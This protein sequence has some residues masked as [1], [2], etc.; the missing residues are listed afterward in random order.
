MHLSCS[1]AASCRGVHEGERATCPGHPCHARA[2]ACCTA[3]HAVRHSGGRRQQRPAQ[4]WAAPATCPPRVQQE[5]CRP[6]R[7][8]RPSRCAFMRERAAH[9]GA[10]IFCSRARMLASA[11]ADRSKRSCSAGAGERRTRACASCCLPPPKLGAA[12]ASASILRVAPG[13]RPLTLQSAARSS[14]R[15]KR[16]LAERAPCISNIK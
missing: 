10:P 14:M 13:G 11:S 15:A 4:D 5:C 8:P 12:P 2:R 9:C 6:E 1:E 16:G 7:V 3:L